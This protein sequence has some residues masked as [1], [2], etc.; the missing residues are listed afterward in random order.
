[1]LKTRALQPRIRSLGGAITELGSGALA[2]L[3]SITVD[4][5]LPPGVVLFEEETPGIEVFL[6]HAGRVK[7][8]CTSRADRTM[9]LRI[10]SPGDILGLSAVISRSCYEVTAKTVSSSILRSVPSDSFRAFLNEH[11][12]ASMIAAQ[13]MSDDYRSA[14]DDVRRLALSE[15]SAA[16]L[17]SVL[18]AWGVAE[19]VGK[20][21][22][23]L[24]MA[25]THEELANLVGCARETVT[26]LLGQ[27][28]RQ[29]LIA[30]HGVS[31]LIPFPERL[32]RIAA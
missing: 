20:T 19:S 17:A 5:A 9:F 11:G 32:E 30:I 21:E 7:L 24:T 15:S 10:A 25:L 18:L 2:H 6:L 4:L 13:M 1:M 23:R 27:F 22:M 8:T 16:R 12:D 29:K 3:A 28:R 14:F 26:R 31:I